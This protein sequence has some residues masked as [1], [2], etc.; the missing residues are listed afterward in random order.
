MSS[1]T[2]RD[3]ILCFHCGYA[4]NKAR[5]ELCKYEYDGRLRVETCPGCSV[6]ITFDSVDEWAFCISCVCLL[7]KMRRLMFCIS[8]NKFDMSESPGE[9]FGHKICEL[10][11]DE[12]MIFDK[13]IEIYPETRKFIKDF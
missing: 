8:C 3:K 1:T 4:E 9:F 12:K 10:M 11:C 13:L 6:S 2:L 5:C 7:I